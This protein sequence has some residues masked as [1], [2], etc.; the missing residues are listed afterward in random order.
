MDGKRNIYLIEMAT[1]AQYISGADVGAKRGQSVA[2]GGWRKD[3][4]RR[5]TFAYM[6]SV[7]QLGI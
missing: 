3:G 4:N 1:F 2:G 6:Y 7:S 5:P